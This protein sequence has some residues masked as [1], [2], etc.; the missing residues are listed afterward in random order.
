MKGSDTFFLHYFLLSLNYCRF[1]G[2]QRKRIYDAFYCKLPELAFNLD[3]PNYM[4]L[5]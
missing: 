3:L 1:E 4:L 2:S 5:Y